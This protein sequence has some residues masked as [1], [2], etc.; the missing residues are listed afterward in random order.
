MM[1]DLGKEIGGLRTELRETTVRIRDYNGL[2]DDVRKYC[3]EVQALKAGTAG[4]DEGSKD[5]RFNIYNV[6]ALAIAVGSIL[7]AI[8]ALFG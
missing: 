6:I 3:E 7:V 4:K 2:R 5:A 1:Q 8:V